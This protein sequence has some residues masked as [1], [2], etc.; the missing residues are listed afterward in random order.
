MIK[1]SVETPFRYRRIGELERFLVMAKMCRVAL[2]VPSVWPSDQFRLRPGMQR[3]A[4]ISISL[5]KCPAVSNHGRKGSI[6]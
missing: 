6:L 4:C 2:L 1:I 5:E 3:E